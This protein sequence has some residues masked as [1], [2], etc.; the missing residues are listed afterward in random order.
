MRNPAPARPNSPAASRWGLG[1][2]IVS[3]AVA[4]ALFVL[5]AAMTVARLLDAT[6]PDIVAGLVQAAAAGWF[7][8]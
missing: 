3:A 5:T 7:P 2:T 4:Y 8:P 1:V 6:P